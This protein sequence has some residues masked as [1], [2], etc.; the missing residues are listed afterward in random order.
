ML[1]NNIHNF[2][3]FVKKIFNEHDISKLNL[4]INKTQIKILM[5][6]SENPD[7][8]MSEIS[9]IAG[10]EKS[11]FSHSVNQ[12][13][14]DGFITRKYPETNRR[15]II[16]SLTVKGRQAAVLI[17][18][19]LDAYLQTLLSGFTAKE[20]KEFFQLINAT[21]KYIGRILEVMNK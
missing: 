13:V 7:K 15:M 2:S 11:A 14:D 5:V 10:I 3:V 9:E 12:L 18:D 1:R 16:L 8:S 20:K 17:K 21:S 19:D 4:G 6:I